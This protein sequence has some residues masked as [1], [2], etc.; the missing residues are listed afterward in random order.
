MDMVSLCGTAGYVL[1]TLLGGRAGV[2]SM[3]AG[4]DSTAT[5]W[6][7][8]AASIFKYLASNE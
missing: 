6:E 8:K 1:V 5:S 3:F 2:D 4:A 7:R